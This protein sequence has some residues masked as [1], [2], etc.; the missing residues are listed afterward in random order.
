MALV[1]NQIVSRIRDFARRR[2][3]DAAGLQEIVDLSSR[4]TAKDLHIDERCDRGSSVRLAAPVT[5]V[6]IADEPA[7]NMSVFIINHAG[8]EIP[9]HDHPGMHGVVKLLHG[10]VQLTQYTRVQGCSGAGAASGD[11]CVTA[12]V[13]CKI[14]DSSPPSLL[15]PAHANIHRLKAITNRAAFFDVLMPRYDPPNVDCHYYTEVRGAR[16]SRDSSHVILRETPCPRH[17][18]SDSMEYLGPKVD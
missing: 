17:F 1:L 6:E 12:P 8:S 10:E 7:F 2:A 15:T 13:T 16:C 5:Y 9:L 3:V 11:F 4:L 14:T 18:W